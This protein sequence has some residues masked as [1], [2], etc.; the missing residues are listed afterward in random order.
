MRPATS[1]TVFRVQSMKVDMSLTK[2]VL[3]TVLVFCLDIL[4]Q[5]R[6]IGRTSAAGDRSADCREAAG[7]AESDIAAK[8]RIFLPECLS[9][10]RLCEGGAISRPYKNSRAAAS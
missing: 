3:L 8:R 7:S 5:T 9:R 10:E 1:T 6:T 2:L 4:E